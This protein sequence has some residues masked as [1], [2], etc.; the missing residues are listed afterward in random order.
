M[1]TPK[2]Y[3]DGVPSAGFPLAP[4]ADLCEAPGTRGCAERQFGAEP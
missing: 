2:G 3:P 1:A 4:G